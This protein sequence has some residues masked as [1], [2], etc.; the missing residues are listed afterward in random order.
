M[1]HPNLHISTE[2]SISGRGTFAG[3]RI[4]AGSELWHSDVERPKLS[5]LQ[6]QLERATGQ[7]EARAYSQIGRNT[8][9]WNAPTE[10]FFN[11]ACSASSNAKM[12]NFVL[13][14]T[15]PVPQGEEIT[16]DYG[17]TEIK[18]K[19]HFWCDCGSSACRIVVSNRDYLALGLRSAQRDLL[20]AYAVSE[21]N[22]ASKAAILNYLLWY[23]LKRIQHILFRRSALPSYLSFI[24]RAFN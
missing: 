11:H 23:S 14:A 6:L 13:V 7:P 20:P 8:Y 3:V 10:Y 19:W 5:R 9:G 2:H 4:E 15:R 16:Y 1:L 21:F 24:A 22:A 12:S 17:M 18:E